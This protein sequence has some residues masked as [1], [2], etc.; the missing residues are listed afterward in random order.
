MNLR[1]Q[2]T[3]VRTNSATEVMTSSRSVTYVKPNVFFPWWGRYVSLKWCI[4]LMI[5][6][7]HNISLKGSTV[8][9]VLERSDTLICFYEKNKKKQKEF[10]LSLLMTLDYHTV[11]MIP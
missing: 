9:F 11:I 5:S 8:V 4:S 10:Q 1:Y 6:T 3:L 7:G 2:P